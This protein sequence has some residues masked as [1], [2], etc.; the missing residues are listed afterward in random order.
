MPTRPFSPATR[1]TII[2]TQGFS[3]SFRKRAFLSLGIIIKQPKESNVS[4]FHHKK[5]HLPTQIV[6]P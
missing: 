3:P 1:L 5:S 4:S 6:P 2:S